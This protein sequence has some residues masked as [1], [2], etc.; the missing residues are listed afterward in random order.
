ML[1]TEQN[2]NLSNS[3]TKLSISKHQ[4]N[5][6]NE[7]ERC[8]ILKQFVAAAVAVAAAVVAVV[9][10][11]A[12]LVF[13]LAFRILHEILSVLS[14]TLVGQNNNKSLFHMYW[15]LFVVPYLEI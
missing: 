14:A 7:D 15:F 10:K 1:S 2:F 8:R 13:L 5:D 6:L 4:S 11:L 12:Q 9:V 3:V